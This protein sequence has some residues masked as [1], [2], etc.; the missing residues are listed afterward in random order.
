MVAFQGISRTILIANFIDPRDFKA[1]GCSARLKILQQATFIGTK[2]YSP[3][4]NG[5]F[6]SD[7]SSII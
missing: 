4:M 6:E 7:I 5:H 3:D 2:V 1:Y